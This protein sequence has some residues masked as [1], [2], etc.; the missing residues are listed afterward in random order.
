MSNFQSQLTLKIEAENRM[1]QEHQQTLMQFQQ[2]SL[3]VFEN[4]AMNLKDL[5]TNVT[6]TTENITQLNSQLIESLKLSV[7]QSSAFQVLLIRATAGEFDQLRRTTA[8]SEAMYLYTS[9]EFSVSANPAIGTEYY[10]S[11][12]FIEK[13]KSCEYFARKIGF[14]TG[15]YFENI[16]SCKRQSFELILQ[17]QSHRKIQTFLI[18]LILTLFTICVLIF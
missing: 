7:H 8:G 10:N 14:E 17:Q 4:I 16:H 1:L 2:Q 13:S 5:E 6:T 18:V 9:S 11:K 3:T 12:R 15:N